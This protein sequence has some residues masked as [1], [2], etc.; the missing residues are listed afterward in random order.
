M[1]DG[2]YSSGFEDDH[3]GASPASSPGAGADG[4]A[5]SKRA[6]RTPHRRAAGPGGGGSPASAKYGSDSDE[7]EDDFEPEDKEEAP[8]DEGGGGGGSSSRSSGA[9]KSGSF[10]SSSSTT[11][12]SAPSQSPPSSSSSSSS[13]GGT[14]WTQVDPDD[15][16]IGQR[17]GGGGFAIVYEGRWRGQH[18]AFKTLFDPRVGDKLKQEFM[19]ELHVMSSLAH[20]NIVD[21]Y[22]ANTRPPK[23]LI[24]MELCDRSLY[25]LLH[26]CPAEPVPVELA[27]RMAR[28]TA[29]GLA[30]LHAQ[31]PAIIHRDIKS[32]NLL[33]TVDKRVKLCDFGLVTTKV[34]AAG[35]PSYMAPELLQ[36]RPFSKK[37]DVYAFAVILWELFTREVPWLG[38]APMEV[39]QMVL[40]GKRPDVPRIDCPYVARGLM[41]RCWHGNPEQRPHFDAVLEELEGWTPPVDHVALLSG[42]GDALDAMFKK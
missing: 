1:S 36:S 11:S 15:I 23:L 25:Q 16:E 3:D 18:V 29:A 7:F 34:T 20:P 32:M 2:E 42:E 17:I 37:V 35:T 4:S 28:D 38:Y 10:S 14:Q 26:Q 27:M 9:S 30:Y 12:S 33:L 21:L 5:S 6:G 41:T 19:D 31:S 40:D 39:R 8:R 24:V 13:D 22:A